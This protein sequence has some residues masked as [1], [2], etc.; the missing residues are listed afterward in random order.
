M[1]PIGSKRLT[2]LLAAFAVLFVAS[3]NS[4]DPNF[5]KTCYRQ[6]V[7]TYSMEGLDE[8]KELN[9]KMCNSV[10]KSCCQVKDQETMY[11]N[12]VHGKEEANIAEH[13]NKNADKYRELIAQL[14]EVQT[15]AVQVKGVIIK[16]I[17][18]CKLLA[19]R[20]LSFEVK[21]VQQKMLDNLEQMKQFF[22]KTYKGF[23]CAI[24]NHDNHK[25]FKKDSM[26]VVFSEKFCRDIVEQNLPSLLT[27]HVDMIKLLNL[28]T[29]FATSCDIRGEYNPESTF[30]KDLIFGQTKE[31]ANSLKACRDNRNKREWFAYCK[32]VCMNFQLVQ[33]PDFFEPNIA[34]I[35]NYNRFL[36]RIN[37][38][39]VTQK[40]KYP[41]ISDTAGKPGSVPGAPAQKRARILEGGQDV[42]SNNLIYRPGLSPKVMLDSWKREFS[43]AGVSLFDEGQNSNISE[44]VYNTVK[45]DLQLARDG[46][47]TQTS[48]LLSSDEKKMLLIAGK[49]ELAGAGRLTVLLFMAGLALIGLL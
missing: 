26:T 18:N 24:C 2:C 40:A 42:K 6:L 33:F 11:T 38:D 35:I 4:Q 17:S 31:I 7:E 29:K 27:F 30:P 10:V 48:V 21:E 15:F 32:E 28:I 12:W 44:G 8:P 25:F 22:V 45:T 14:I 41:M 19:E 36:K 13:Y 1:K 3:V 20:I 43:D 39:I 46:S 37:Q 16:K 5:Q 23:Y 34:E 49:R 9:L 47:S